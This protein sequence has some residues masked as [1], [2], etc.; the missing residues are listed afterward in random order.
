MQRLFEPGRPVPRRA[1]LA[2]PTLAPQVLALDQTPVIGLAA[3][4][5]LLADLWTGRGVP[6]EIAMPRLQRVA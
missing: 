6:G 3:A 1:L 4:E 2:A 5:A